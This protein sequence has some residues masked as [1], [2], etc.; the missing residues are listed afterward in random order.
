MFRCGRGL[1]FGSPHC[2]EGDSFRTVIGY[3]CG[4]SLADLSVCRADES[5]TVHHH[6]APLGFKRLASIESRCTIHSLHVQARPVCLSGDLAKYPL[7]PVTTVL[8]WFPL[9]RNRSPCQALVMCRLLSTL[10]IS[11]KHLG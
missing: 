6:R 10:L 5:L 9:Y 8:Q 3:L 1:N 4:R 2:W 11:P 7:E